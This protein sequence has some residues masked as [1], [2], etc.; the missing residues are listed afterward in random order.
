METKVTKVG[1]SLPKETFIQIERLRH[2]IGLARSAAFLEAIQLW[3]HEKRERELEER[4]A[5]GYR[6][7]PERAAE[8]EPFFRAGLASFSPERW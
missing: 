6:Q 8:A 3:L 7:K 5:K 4:Y 2:E 1:I